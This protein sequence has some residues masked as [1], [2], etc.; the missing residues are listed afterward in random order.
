[1]NILN[2]VLNNKEYLENLTTRI[3]II[4]MLLNGNTLT[5]AETYAIL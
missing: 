3:P 1:M 2:F 5:Y 4:Q